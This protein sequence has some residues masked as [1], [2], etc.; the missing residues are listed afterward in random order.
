MV[1][2]QDV[3]NWE[4]LTVTEW[5]QKRRTTK[6]RRKKSWRSG[7]SKSHP[8][9][10]PEWIETKRRVVLCGLVLWT[11]GV[12]SCLALALIFDGKMEGL[13]SRNPRLRPPPTPFI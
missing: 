3:F 2:R 10:Y 4:R 5:Q 13:P 12:F 9:K 1:E 6:K 8:K 7:T 11:F